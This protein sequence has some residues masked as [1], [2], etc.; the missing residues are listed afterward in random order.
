MAL[1]YR[2]RLAP[3]P[4]GGLH[5]GNARTAL[6]AWLR[7]RAA[8]GKLVMRIEDID[9]P[10]VQPGSIAAILEDLRWLGLDWDEGPQPGSERSAAEGPHAP[11]LQSARGEFYARAIETLRTRG[12]V[13][14]CTCSRREIAEVAS[15]PHGD[16]GP[17]YP[18]TCR[19]GPRPNARP[20]AL[21]F[22]MESPAP[23]FVDGF[24][25]AYEDPTADDFVLQR[26]DGVY[27]YQLAVVVDDI[28]MGVSEV[29]RGDDL[30]SSTPR[31]IALYRALDAEPPRFFHV[32]L[33]LGSDGRRLSKRFGAPALAA[34][35]DAGLQ[36]AQIVGRLAET[37]GLVEPG[38]AIEA[39]RLIERF[40]VARLPAAPIQI[41]PSVDAI[42]RRTA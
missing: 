4:T 6:V 35:R 32:P 39:G 34:Y 41:D 2:G 29:V 21:R 37:L 10:R 23:R 18:G 27:A 15:A 17:L 36:P 5:F 30:L 1:S 9:T 12:R 28:A 25:G 40:E 11:Y 31:Q 38:E 14:P 24:L 3:S 42:A 33:V 8:G 13:Y 7:V 19:N 26:G 20:A 22:R 16:L